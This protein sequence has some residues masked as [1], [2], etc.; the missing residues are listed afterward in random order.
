MIHTVDLCFSIGRYDVDAKNTE[1]FVLYRHF[2]ILEMKRSLV[3]DY[4]YVQQHTMEL[5]SI[6]G[7]TPATRHR[8]LQQIEELVDSIESGLQYSMGVKTAILIADGVGL[9]FYDDKVYFF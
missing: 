4:N 1:D 6:T 9:R 2:T 3:R 5:P 8:R 7:R